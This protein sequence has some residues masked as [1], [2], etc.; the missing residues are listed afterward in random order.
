MNIIH[1]PSTKSNSQVWVAGITLAACWNACSWAQSPGPPTV[2]FRADYITQS[3]G[4]SRPSES[5]SL[6]YKDWKLI[7][8]Q[9]CGDSNMKLSWETL[10]K[11]LKGRQRGPIPLQLNPSSYETKQFANSQMFSISQVSLITLLPSHITWYLANSHVL[12]VLI[13]ISVPL[14]MSNSHIKT[15]AP[16][17]TSLNFL[18]CNF[19]SLIIHPSLVF[20]FLP[21]SAQ[22]TLVDWTTTIPTISFSKGT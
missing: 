19:H 15:W 7:F 5:E 10:C 13:H 8:K 6:E 20:L 14:L 12:L 3:P 18:V 4:G 21:S 9:L 1:P 17:L 11:C 2:V 22:V 16:Y